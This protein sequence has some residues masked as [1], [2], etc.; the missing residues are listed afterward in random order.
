M[1][2]NLTQSPHAL[3]KRIL[4]KNVSM[5]DGFWAAQQTIHHEIRWKHAYRTLEASGNFNNVKLAAGTRRRE[6]S[7]FA[8]QRDVTFGSVKR[9]GI[10]EDPG[11]DL[12]RV[13]LSRKSSQARYLALAALLLTRAC[14]FDRARRSKPFGRWMDIER[15]RNQP[16]NKTLRK[17]DVVCVS[18]FSF[19]RGERI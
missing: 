3:L 17:C 2:I 14:E 5:K 8:Y 11:M 6:Y 19:Q 4:L 18:T 12:V 9:D 10:P 1:E 16:A 13:R 7:R 15:R